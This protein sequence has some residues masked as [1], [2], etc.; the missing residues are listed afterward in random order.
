MALKLH[1]D[2][3]VAKNQNIEPLQL[4]AAQSLAVSGGSVFFATIPVLVGIRLLP[5][6][7][8]TGSKKG[9][10]NYRLTILSIFDIIYR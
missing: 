6:T 4:M 3:I 7:P 8:I 1:S 9:Y 10:D 2:A 5:I